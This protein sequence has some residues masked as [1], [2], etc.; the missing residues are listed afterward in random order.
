ML[1]VLDRGYQ[2]HVIVLEPQE[3][4]IPPWFNPEISLEELDM[5]LQALR[6][7]KKETIN[8]ARLAADEAPFT[9]QGLQFSNDAKS[10][11]SIEATQS[12]ISNRQALPPHWVG[13]WKAT[14]NE[15]LPISSVDDWHNFYEAYYE[16][17]ARNFAKAQ[18]LK[19]LVDTVKGIQE[20]QDISWNTPTP[21]DA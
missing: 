6:R 16:H 21:L 14:T 17:S 7:A 3:P 4:A 8:R 18:F 9:Y 2:P 10:R 13:G 15:I 11:A 1:N 19:D 20:T 5:H 12:Q